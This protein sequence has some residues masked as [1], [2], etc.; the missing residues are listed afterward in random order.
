MKESKSKISKGGG[1]FN[2]VEGETT[3]AVLARLKADPDVAS[4][5]RQRYPG[6]EISRGLKEARE[7]AGL[8]QDQVAARM[9]TTR[10]AVSRLESAGS[11]HPSMRQV[12]KFTEAIGAV[13]SFEVQLVAKASEAARAHA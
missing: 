11:T 2:P 3:T 8:T 1:G 5:F 12:L 4:I 10:T 13:C 9:S 6:A 7:A